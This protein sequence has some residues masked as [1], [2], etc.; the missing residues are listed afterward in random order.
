MEHE[1]C[2]IMSYQTTQMSSLC[3]S[4]SFR[5]LMASATNKIGFCHSFVNSVSALPIKDESFYNSYY[6]LDFFVFFR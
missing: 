1:I 2:F 5:K 4:L 3:D 6:A